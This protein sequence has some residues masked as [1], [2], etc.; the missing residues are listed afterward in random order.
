MVVKGKLCFNSAII[1]NDSFI[2]D[3]NE[4]LSEYGFEPNYTSE[5]VNGDTI[6]FESVEE[7]LAYDN[8]S[9]RAIKSMDISFGYGNSIRIEPEAYIWGMYKSTIE[10]RIEMDNNDRVEEIKR[11]LELIFDKHKQTKLY[12]LA[13]K[14]SMG[15]VYRGIFLLS[16]IL[17]FWK[18]IIP[19]KET[20]EV[21]NYNIISVVIVGIV[22]LIAL[23]RAVSWV[24]SRCFPPIVF[25]LGDN[26]R[27][28]EKESKTKSNV[29]WVIIVGAIVGTIVSVGVTLFLR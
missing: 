13:S 21:V 14:F 20:V 6:K 17:I 29:F 8:Y 10:V 16:V 22:V 5:L 25:Y 11:K 12:T 19:P 15:Y 27:T 4:L 2:R 26:I 3:I 18:L 28:I 9:N 1:V 23:E 24:I 7:L